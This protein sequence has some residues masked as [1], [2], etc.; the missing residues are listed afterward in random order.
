MGEPAS[1]AGPFLAQAAEEGYQ[2]GRS[3]SWLLL[4]QPEGARRGSSR[5]CEELSSGRRAERRCGSHRLSRAIQGQWR[6]DLYH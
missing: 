5:R 6:H 3:L 4:P 1:P 2:K